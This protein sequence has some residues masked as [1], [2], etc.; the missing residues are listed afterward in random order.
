[1]YRP[2]VLVSLQQRLSEVLKRERLAEILAGRGVYGAALIPGGAL[3]TCQIWGES[4]SEQVADSSDDFD[5]EA[6]SAQ[7]AAYV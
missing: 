3:L 4:S 5:D 2:A 1:M 6:A 7:Q